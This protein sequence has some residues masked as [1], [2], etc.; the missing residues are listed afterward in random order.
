MKKAPVI[1][2]IFSDSSSDSD[3]LEPRRAYTSA[4]DSAHEGNRKAYQTSID[5]KSRKR[6]ITNQ[7][8]PPIIAEKDN[9]PLG[10]VSFDMS[11]LSSLG[12]NTIIQYVKTNG[13]QIGN[14]FFKNYDQIGNQITV[15]FYKHDKRN[16]SESMN[17]IKHIY[18]KSVSGGDN[19]L[20]DTIEIPKNQW[21]DLKRDMIISYEKKANHEWIYRAKFNTFTKAK[22]GSTRMSM[23]SERGYILNPDKISTIRRYITS[24]D[25]LTNYIIDQLQKLEFRVKELEK[26]A[27]HRS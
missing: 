19:P 25:K 24:N 16:Y 13:K 18:I 17:N 21:K 6:S 10:Y 9:A 12:Q 7:V 27:K 5:E 20:K 22:D 8:R 26:K 1:G 2:T 14:K 23:T 4:A 15:G 11:K 3:K